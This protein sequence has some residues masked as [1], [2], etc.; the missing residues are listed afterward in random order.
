MNGL[1]D[2]EIAHLM[3]VMR[4]SLTGDLAGPILT[5]AYWR[6]RLHDL[7]NAPA[8]TKAQLCALDSLLVELDEFD[9]GGFG[10]LFPHPVYA[11][12]GTREMQDVAQ[13]A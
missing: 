2:R 4:P 3:R 1:I 11:A 13:P 7:L 10:I 5:S 9:A 6:K 12:D 8:L